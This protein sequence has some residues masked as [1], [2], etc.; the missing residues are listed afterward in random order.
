MLCIVALRD[1]IPVLEGVE[2][3]VGFGMRHNEENVLSSIIASEGQSTMADV[4]DGRNDEGGG[5]VFK[6]R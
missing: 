4:V 3:R 5:G 2:F 1:S 6:A